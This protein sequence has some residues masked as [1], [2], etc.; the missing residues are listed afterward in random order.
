M[1]SWEIYLMSLKHTELHYAKDLVRIK[2]LPNKLL[3]DHM[4]SA[5]NWET[6]NLTDSTFD[7]DH[8]GG[9]LNFLT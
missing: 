7:C 2:D 3:I 4:V 8:Y 1:L 6:I 5:F 9:E